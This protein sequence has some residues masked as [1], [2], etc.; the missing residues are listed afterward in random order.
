MC[1]ESQHVPRTRGE[2]RLVYS[3]S[4][5]MRRAGNAIESRARRLRIAA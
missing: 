1:E 2:T 4:L 3:R 5:H